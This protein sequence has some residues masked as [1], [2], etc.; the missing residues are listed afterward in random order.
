MEDIEHR[1]YSSSLKMFKH[2]KDSMRRCTSFSTNK[3]LFDLQTSFKNVF[4]HYK[5]LLK[6]R[7]PTLSYDLT[8]EAL[9]FGLPGSNETLKQLPDK[10]M[11]DEVELK[12]VY[13]INTCEYCLDI[14]P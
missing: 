3:A 11:S 9:K 8:F 12:C 14:V 4:R 6:R 5:N 13:I 10:P 7:I 1:V 2:I